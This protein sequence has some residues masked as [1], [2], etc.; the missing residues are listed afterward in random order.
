MWIS[1]TV[2][3]DSKEV[4]EVTA[5]NDRESKFN[6]FKSPLGNY[7]VFENLSNVRNIPSMLKIECNAGQASKKQ[8]NSETDGE[9]LEVNFIIVFM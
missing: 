9:N 7:F 1:D 3:A 5:P 4:I 2:C 8:E 6:I